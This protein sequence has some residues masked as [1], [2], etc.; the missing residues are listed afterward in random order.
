MEV[1]DRAVFTLQKY[2]VKMTWKEYLGIKL[3]DGMYNEASQPYLKT[4]KKEFFLKTNLPRIIHQAD[5]TAS[6]AEYDSWAFPKSS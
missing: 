2:G 1:T 4:Y 5:F 6:R 3:A